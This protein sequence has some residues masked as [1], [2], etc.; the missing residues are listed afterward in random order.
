MEIDYGVIIGFIGAVCVAGVLGL[1]YVG[2][3]MLGHARGR[4][5]AAR[6]DAR[7]G[8]AD[9]LLAVESAVDSVSRA[10]DRLTDAQRIVLLQQVRAAELR[11]PRPGVARDPLRNTPA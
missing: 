7:I 5:E 4:R 8:D 6:E 2:A 9:R 10:I 11:E 1:S 3:C